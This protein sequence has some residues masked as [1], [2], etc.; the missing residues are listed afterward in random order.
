MKIIYHYDEKTLQYVGFSEIDE[1]QELPDNT[2][3]IPLPEGLYKPVFKDG[4]WINGISDEEIKQKHFDQ[5]AAIQT[6]TDLQERIR[7]APVELVQLGQTTTEREL[8]S[9]EQ[10]QKVTDLELQSME[11]GQKTTDLEIQ[12]MEQGQLVTEM[13]LRLLTLEAKVG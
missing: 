4:A 8:E 2:T 6:K 7:Q 12:A 11:Q 1:S 9:M 10:G 5:N 3:D 13:E